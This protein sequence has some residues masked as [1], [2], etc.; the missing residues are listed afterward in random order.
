MSTRKA[1]L[2]FEDDDVIVEVYDSRYQLF[3]EFRELIKQIP[4]REL[5]D[6]NTKKLID[7]LINSLNKGL[8]PHLT[9]WQSK[10]RKRFEKELK[11]D[12]NEEKS[13]QEIQKTFPEYKEVVTDLQKINGELVEYTKE[14]KKLIE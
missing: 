10:F 2:L 14:L 7:I 4:S 3:T 11:K 5:K 12:E 6:P 1:G 8:R 13:C 9:K